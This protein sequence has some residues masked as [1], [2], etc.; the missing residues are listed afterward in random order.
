MG[1]HLNVVM[2]LIIFGS[3]TYVTDHDDENDDVDEDILSFLIR[4]H[5]KVLIFY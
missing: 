2:W 3:K 1:Q 5:I 4:K